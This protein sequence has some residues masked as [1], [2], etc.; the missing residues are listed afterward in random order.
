LYKVA[1]SHDPQAWKSYP[2]EKSVLSLPGWALPS[3]DIL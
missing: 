2:V 1:L 3:M